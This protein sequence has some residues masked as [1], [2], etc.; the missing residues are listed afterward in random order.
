MLTGVCLLLRQDVLAYPPLY[1]LYV[2]TMY[3]A[4]EDHGTLVWLKDRERER[5]LYQVD[6]E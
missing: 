6:C 4:S 1:I 3:T 5:E 2:S